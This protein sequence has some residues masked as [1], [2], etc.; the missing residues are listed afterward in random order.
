MKQYVEKIT[1]ANGSSSQAPINMGVT[2]YDNKYF[3]TFSSTLV[4]R[5]IQRDFFRFLSS[6]GVDITLETN[7]LEV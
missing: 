2:K 3:L 7:E 4:D 6:E 5:A 1:F